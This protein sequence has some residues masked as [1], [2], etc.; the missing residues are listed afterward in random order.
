MTRPSTTLIAALAGIAALSG[1]SALTGGPGNSDIERVARE[2]MAA[3]L[4]D[5]NANPAAK[6]ALEKA[7]ADATISPKGMCN[8]QAE[9]GVQVCAVDVNI[10]MPGTAAKASQPFIVKLTK[11]SD[12]KWKGAPD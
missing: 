8:G 11:G 5:P 10:Q 3:S 4:Q 9:P 7:L 1:C 12:G 2:Q 6:A